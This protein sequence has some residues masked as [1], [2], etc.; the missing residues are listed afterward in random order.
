[1]KS[2]IFNISFDSGTGCVRSIILEDDPYLMNWRGQ[3]HEWGELFTRHRRTAYNWTPTWN[4]NEPLRLDYFRE[5]INDSESIYKCSRLQV[6]VKRSFTGT[7]R[8]KE[9]YIFT[10]LSDSELFCRKGE[11][12]IYTTFCDEYTSALISQTTKCHA[13]V[14]CGENASWVNALRQGISDKNLGLVLTEGSINCYS[15]D[16][17]NQKLATATRGNIILSPK[18]PPLL[19]GESYTISWELF[20]HSGTEAFKQ[21]IA[22]ENNLFDISAGLYTIFNSENFE[23]NFPYADGT[24]I[25]CDGKDIPYTVKNN[26]I[27]VMYP[28]HKF[29]EHKFIIEQNGKHT[30]ICM[31]NADN[32]EELVK[33][34]LYYIADKQQYHRKG[35]HLDGAYLIYDTK[36]DYLYFNNENSD[37]NASRERLGMGLAMTKYLQTHNDPKLM[38]SLSEYVNFV[39]REFV[40]TETGEVFN[41]VGKNPNAKRLYNAPWAMT[42]MAELFELTG[43]EKYLEYLHRI[44][45]HYYSL[46]G[47]KFYPNGF[48]PKDIISAFKKG[49]KDDYAKSAM[50]NF[51]THVNNMLKVGLDYPA[52]EVIYEQTIVTPAVTMICDMGI[53]LND[54]DYVQKVD[55]HHKTLERFSGMQPDYRLNGI[56]IRYWDDYWFGKAALFGDTLPHYWSCLSARSDND[57]Y[58]LSGDEKY[59]HAAENCI[60]NCLCLF[61]RD[62]GASC[63]YVYP[64][65]VDDH[66]GEF[67]DDW[68]NDQDFALYFAM[69]ILDKN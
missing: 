18:I 27:Y 41:T 10:N 4:F 46:G 61:F 31:Y 9:S 28:P 26:R 44:T 45:D 5:S 13:H 52:H 36:D 57:F 63:A 54:Y 60:R 6:S 17:D 48:S 50:E 40:D 37:H 66:D 22:K 2:N 42:F 49:G 3:T 24:K 51:K 30:H 33:K 14:W 20:E 65:C 69:Q 15:I 32:F 12:G 19:P 8:F 59:K 34:R 62:G 25:T 43:D 35:S 47:E 58:L 21:I 7:G 16:R 67:Y 29:G 55:A 1:M 56:A 23:F 64:F 11:V 68:A 39:L 38:D 53:M